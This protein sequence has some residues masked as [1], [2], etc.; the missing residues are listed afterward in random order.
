M[1]DDID[2]EE[3]ELVSKLESVSLFN[4]DQEE[5]IMAGALKDYEM[6]KIE[7]INFALS[8]RVDSL[9]SSLVNIPLN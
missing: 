2:V 7:A 4:P 1:S 9:F 3:T 5:Q 8:H 6:P